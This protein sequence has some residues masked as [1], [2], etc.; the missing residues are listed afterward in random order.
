MTK[1]PVVNGRECIS[2]LQRGGFVID[3]QKGSHI[4]LIRDNP[5]A[6]ATV[7]NHN[8]A[9]KPGTLRSII[10]QAGLTVDE[11]VALL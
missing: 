9:L 4:T 3:R 10:R 8:K 6:R 7:P 1:L 5:F 2:A 11:F